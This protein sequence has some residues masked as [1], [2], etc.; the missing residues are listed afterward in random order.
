MFG[1]ETKNSV[2]KGPTNISFRHILLSFRPEFTFCSL[3]FNC[4][5]LLLLIFELFT[6]EKTREVVD[7]TSCSKLKRSKKRR[8]QSTYS[9]RGSL[10]SFFSF[11]EYFENIH[12]R[13][14]LN[15]HPANLCLFLSS[16]SKQC[17]LFSL[18]NLDHFLFFSTVTHCW[19]L[20]NYQFLLH[21][22]W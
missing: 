19:K 8:E 13:A 11:H 5:D 1:T 14:F 3:P 12:F 18:S 9:D 20:L 2:H 10:S 17:T 16:S 4:Y 6:G 7:F 15:T 21:Y 22:N